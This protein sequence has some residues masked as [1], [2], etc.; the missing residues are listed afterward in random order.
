MSLLPLPPTFVLHLYQSDV[1]ASSQGR[2]TNDVLEPL[3]WDTLVLQRQAPINSSFSIA[4]A[5]C[6]HPTRS[7]AFLNSKT[8]ADMCSSELTTHQ[9]RRRLPV[10]PSLITSCSFDL[11][12]SYYLAYLCLSPSRTSGFLSFP[13]GILS[14]DLS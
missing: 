12:S 11:A 7:K 14:S 10:L 3:N 13:F 2:T 6:S 1:G 9:P 4:P 5:H 8:R